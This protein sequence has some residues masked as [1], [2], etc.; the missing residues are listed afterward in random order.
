[1]QF[2][3]FQVDGEVRYGVIEG[4]EVREL[5]RNFLEGATPMRTTYALDDVDLLAP[6]RPSKMLCLGLNYRDHAEEMGKPLP[7]EPVL[8]LKPATA[9]A[10]P[11]QPIVYPKMA[12]RVDHEAELAIVIGRRCRSVSPKKVDDVIFGYTCF[13]DV[14]ARDLQSK[15]GQWSRAK[16]FDTFGVLG[17][18]VETDPG[19]PDDLAVTCRLNGEVRQSSRTD[20]LVFDC[21]SVVC[22]ASRIMTLEAGDVIA[23][24]TPSGIGPMEPGDE[25]E[26]EV[27]GIG[28][29][30]NPV[31]AEREKGA[32][33]AR[34]L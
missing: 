30:A 32:K 15:D 27:E 26:V 11:G 23:T 19:D 33:P 12:G 7:E 8:F 20:Q 3:R 25:V 4:G 13:N 22:W 10:G 17:P 1:M 21:R 5:L 31:E 34:I 16:G 24:G 14:T 18:W 9:L 28:V 6:C 2:V 29:L